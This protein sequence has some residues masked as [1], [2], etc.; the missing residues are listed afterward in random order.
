MGSDAANDE[1]GISRAEADALVRE[2]ERLRKQIENLEQRISQLDQLA[3]L[4]PLLNLPNRR[5]FVESLERV[6]ARVERDGD[7]ASMVFVDV[8]GLKTIN[9]Q[10]GHKSGDE[11]LIEVGQMLIASGGKRV[12]CQCC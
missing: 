1:G 2:I 7:P 11:A 9:D 4:D 12:D 6:I 10:F 3:H 5:S 8:D